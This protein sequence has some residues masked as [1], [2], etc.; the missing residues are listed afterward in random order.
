M[1]HVRII[2]FEECD[3]DLEGVGALE[4]NKE[5]SVMWIWYL[6]IWKS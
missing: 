6:H 3:E 2:V 1:Y 4:V 5:A